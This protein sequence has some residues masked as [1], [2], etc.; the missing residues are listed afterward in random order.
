MKNFYPK[1]Q[2][3]GQQLEQVIVLALSAPVTGTIQIQNPGRRLQ[4]REFEYLQSRSQ[5]PRLTADLQHP[6]Q[7]VAPKPATPVQ[8]VPVRLEH[9]PQIMGPRGHSPPG[10]RTRRGLDQRVG[11]SLS[12]SFRPKL[13]GVTAVPPYRLPAATARQPVLCRPP[14]A[15]RA[16][17]SSVGAWSAPG[18]G[19]TGD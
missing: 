6:Q 13:R 12:Q 3:C 8:R 17:L 16:Q 15:R 7:S 9:Q 14:V 18:G 1:L 4:P 2:A 10:Q 11:K 19:D 5:L